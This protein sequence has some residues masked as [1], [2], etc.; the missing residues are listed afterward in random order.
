MT[1][2]CPKCSAPI[3]RVNT[4]SIELDGVHRD[5]KGVAYLC[6]NC[7]AVVSVSID[8]WAVMTQAVSEISDLLGKGY[9]RSHSTK[10]A[11]SGA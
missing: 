7:N 8:Q 2:N 6:Q 3:T 9:G 4:S 5:L 10:R 11:A 1:G